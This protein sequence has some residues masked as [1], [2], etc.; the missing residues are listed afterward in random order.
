MK[1]ENEQK[2]ILKNKEKILSQP[3]F[4]HYPHNLKYKIKMNFLENEHLCAFLGINFL[5]LIIW[6]GFK[7]YSSS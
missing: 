5:S 2:L 6:K 4:N 1:C 7:N 3:E